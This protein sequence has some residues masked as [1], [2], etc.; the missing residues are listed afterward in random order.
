[1]LKVAVPFPAFAVPMVTPPSLKVTV[2]V[3]ALLVTVAVRVTR[4]PRV[5]GVGE[6]VTS[7]MAM[8][9]ATV[10]VPLA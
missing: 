8:A 6:E 7:Q 9:L 2:P 3:A 10:S 5:D 4:W 1:M